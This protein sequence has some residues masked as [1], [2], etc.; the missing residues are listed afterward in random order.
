MQNTYNSHPIFQKS[1]YGPE[2]HGYAVVTVLACGA[3][4]HWFNCDDR[5]EKNVCQNMLH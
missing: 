2:K 1:V 5:Q 3:G 4:G